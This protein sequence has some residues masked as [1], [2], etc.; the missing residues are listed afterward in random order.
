M[1]ANQ[2]AVLVVHLVLNLGVVHGPQELPLG[3]TENSLRQKKL[4]DLMKWWF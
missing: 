1:L 3:Q 2:Y 4:R